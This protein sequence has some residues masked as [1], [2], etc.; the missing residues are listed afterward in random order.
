MSSD[1]AKI[2]GAT[3]PEHF[4]KPEISELG[5]E[6]GVDQNLPF[7]TPFYDEDS[8]KK[9]SNR[10]L[11]E[12]LR[13]T[14]DDEGPSVQQLVTMRQMDGQARALYR[15]LTLPIKSALSKSTFVPAEGGEKEAE[16]IDSVFRLPPQQ[17]GMSVTFHH[18]MS[19]ILSGLFTGFSAFEQVY[20][21]PSFG[22]LKGKFTLKK[23]AFRP[24]ETVT[25]ITD[26]TGGFAG[27]R[28]RAYVAGKTIDVYI[29]KEYAF[30]YACLTGDTKIS[31]L[32]GTEVPIQELAD[33]KEPF[34]L[35][36]VDE[37]GNIVP[38]KALRAWK[39]GVRSDLVEVELDN[40]ECVR[41]TSDHQFMLRDGS[42]REAAQLTAGDSL[43]P[44][45]RKQEK[46]APKARGYEKLYQPHGVWEWTHRVVNTYLEGS[47]KKNQIIHHRNVNPLNND[48]SNLQ[49]VTRAE[50]QAIHKVLFNAGLKKYQEAGLASSNLK[51]RWT[52]SDFREKFEASL[53]PKRRL[54]LSE[55]MRAMRSEDL[56]SD[57]TV[58]R[59]SE[60]CVEVGASRKRVSEV[61]NCD[62]ALVSHR[63]RQAG[64]TGTWSNFAAQFGGIPPARRTSEQR[65]ADST[66]MK[67]QL[68]LMWAD[69]EYRAMHSAS[70]SARMTEFWKDSAKREIHS[71]FMKEKWSD[72]EWS[73]AQG[74]LISAGKQSAKDPNNHKVVLVRHLSISE[75]VYDIEVEKHH[76]FAT[77]AGVFVHNCQE[78]ERK[79]YGVSFFQSA[80]Y[81]YD[82]KI[83]MYYIAHLA[84]QRAAVG[85]RVGT[86]PANA[87]RGAKA[88]FA[89]NLSNLALAQW[90]MVPEGFKVE[91]LKE[92]GTFPFLDYINHHNSQMSKSILAGFFDENQGSGA[93]DKAAV[94]F[95]QPGD[96]MFMLM[97]QSI[98]D[99]V[100]NQ[101]NHY[102]IPRL[103]DWN[104]S[105]GKY[106]IFQ[107]AALTEEQKASISKTFDKL[108]TA[109]QSMNVTPEFMRELEKY[110]A[111]EMGLKIDFDEIEKEEEE[112]EELLAQQQAAAVASE[113]APA[114]APEAALAAAPSDQEISAFEDAAG[115]E[116]APE[117]KL[118]ADDELVIMANELLN[119]AS[120][121]LTLTRRVKTFAG[122]KRFQ[123]PIGSIILDDSDTSK[124]RPVTIE[125]L[126]SLQSQVQA[127]KVQK[128]DATV[129]AASHALMLAVREYAGGRDPKTVYATLKRLSGSPAPK[130]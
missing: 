103:V 119:A 55:R 115:G 16:F 113:A 46:L 48:P 64:F 15:L 84:A 5:L 65:T 89:T 8:K 56:R 57:I 105:G 125:R 52:T 40:G 102:I 85:T 116:A 69:P 60:V 63:L 39:T 12:L 37:V 77:S 74:D 49:R 71:K 120:D 4:D 75:D 127:A 96:D 66:R 50:H 93:N 118:S 101:I 79:F 117:V 10:Q 43:M 17:G 91:M 13:E 19:Q 129:K 51:L 1:T 21:K 99:D 54:E 90:M 20:W 59:I 126:M 108:S 114:A 23:L 87:S 121:S 76:N 72:P 128:N 26:D 112:E 82:K 94:S 35:Y 130:K 68:A 62:P 7:T 31:L 14:G 47:Y 109:G 73:V 3:G 104:F 110:M 36:S 24:P 44:L 41:A 106:P 38:G 32:D 83:K 70:S 22:P 107:W 45:Y 6:L 58:E 92:Q 100:A 80:F 124:K 2:T 53:T 67:A 86:V 81:H 122:V 11:M 78:E 25:F 111:G 9:N 34:W 97:L 123:N 42:Y 28:Q 61:L 98:M 95:G 30:Y 88:E 18:F 29:K 33:R 27:F